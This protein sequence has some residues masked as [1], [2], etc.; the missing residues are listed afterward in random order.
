MSTAVNR[1]EKYDVYI[2]T[3]CPYLL[4]PFT[5]Y[6]VTNFSP[7]VADCE[8]QKNRRSIALAAPISPIPRSNLEAID[9]NDLSRTLLFHRSL[10]Q[11]F[12]IS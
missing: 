6:V 9:Y 1:E 12:V 5:R 2:L 8:N 7:E 3:G 11:Q 10:E 4:L